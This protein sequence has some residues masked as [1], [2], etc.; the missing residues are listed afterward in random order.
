MKTIWKYQSG[1]TQV[2]N[3]VIFVLDLPSSFEVVHI[4]LYPVGRGCFLWIALDTE[5][6]TQP[7]TF[8]VIDTGQEIPKYKHGVKYISTLFDC[9]W[10]GH[11][12]HKNV[13]SDELI[14]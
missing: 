8:H 4:K 12:L 2:G 1:W 14:N 6:K 3:D 10:V 5:E 9:G 7:T 11:I 13:E